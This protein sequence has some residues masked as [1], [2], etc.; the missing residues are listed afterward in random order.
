MKRFHM[1]GSPLADAHET[2]AMK[3][4]TPSLSTS[5]SHAQ[6]HA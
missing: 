4:S 6:V 3:I 1:H 5:P 2:H